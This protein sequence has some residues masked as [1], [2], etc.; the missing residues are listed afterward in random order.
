MG[1]GGG[2]GG[3]VGT[4]ADIALAAKSSNLP[5]P[6]AKVGESVNHPSSCHVT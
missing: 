3:K 1:K 5:P 2:A 4:L 6:E